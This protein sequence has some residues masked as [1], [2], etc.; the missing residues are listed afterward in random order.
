MIR[1]F[2][3]KVFVPTSAISVKS[4]SPNDARL[5]L[6]ASKFMV[7]LTNTITSKEGQR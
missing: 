2:F 1:F 4:H 5:S 7:W 6:I 3:L